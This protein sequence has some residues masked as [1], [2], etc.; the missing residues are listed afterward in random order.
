MGQN[1]PLLVQRARRALRR[2]DPSIESRTFLYGADFGTLPHEEDHPNLVKIF[3]DA[4]RDYLQ[5]RVYL[6]SALVT[7]PAGETVVVHSTD[8]PPTEESERNLLIN[9]VGGV[10]TAMRQVADGAQAPVHLYCY[11]RYDQRVLLEALKRHLDDVSALPGFFDLMTQTPALSQ[12]IISFLSSELQERYNLGSVCTPLHDAARML[13]F[14]WA[15]DQ[16]EYYR[17][18]RAR[19]FDN[20]RDVIRQPDGQLIP[21]GKDTPQDMPNRLTI[22]AA[23]RFNSQI[24]LE[25]AYAAWGCLP[26]D[27]EDDRTLLPFRQITLAHLQA[28]AG[29]RVRA[30]AHIE[31]SFKYKAR[32]IEKP[33]F[34][35]PNLAQ[36]APAET[37]LAK[38]LQEFLF[39]EHHAAVQAKLLTYSLPIER[40]VQT[41]LALLLRYQ[42]EQVAGDTYRFMID[43]ETVGLDLVLTLNALR[44]KEGDWVVINPAEASLRASKIKNGRLATIKAIGPDW[45]ELN[46][47]GMTF[48][49]STFRYPHNNKLVPESGQFYTLDEMA[50]DMNADKTLEALG[51][52]QENIL[53][54]WLLQRSNQRQVTAQTNSFVTQF[55]KLIDAIEKPRQLTRPQHEVIVDRLAEPLFLVQGPP[56][57]G[58][59]H[60]LAWAVL[61]R[62]AAHAAQ[63]Q[64]CHV[65]VSCKTHNAVNIVLEALAAKWQRL[66]NAV[67]ASVK[68]LQ[69][70]QIYKLVNDETDD[71]PD[72]VQP[73]QAFCNSPQTLDKLM[74]QGLIVIGGT[75][76][77][78]Y[79]LAKY[80]G[81]GGKKIDWSL[82]SFDLVVVDEASQMSLPEGILAC[83]FLKLTGSAIVVG[84]HRQMPPIIAHNWESEEKRSIT[85]TLPYL[86]LFDAL[87]ERDFPRVA[88]DESFRLHQTVAE[89]LQ[90]N[91]YI[92]D[93][94][95]FFSRRKELLPAV[96]KTDPFIDL[97]LDSRYP[98][99]VIE[100]S[101]RQSQQYNELEIALVEPLIDACTTH[102]WLDGHHGV[103]VVVPHRAQKARLREHFPH[104]AAAEAIDTVERFQGGERDVII[105]SATVSDPDYVLAEADFL[106][107]LNRLNVA[108]S[109]P[110]KK[111]I[112]VASRSVIE[113]LTSDLEV[114]ENAMIW[115]RLY[116]Q[117]A[118][119]LLWQGEQCG[120][121]ISVRGRQ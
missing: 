96:P 71:V 99:V 65:A 45:I 42:G 55:T 10:I 94:I 95:H 60:T 56:G 117:Y 27:S 116:Y 59:S 37:T 111:L 79:N 16:Y 120:V 24:P 58:K 1:L 81:A 15:D 11:N 74:T 114:F 110:R 9:W 28:F 70:L 76:G 35:L 115:K 19:L 119:D 83:A 102:L 21:A 62:L 12:S 40:R 8:E 38:S 52:T 61:A 78:L 107:N 30:L 20:R 4:Q 63:G 6:I 46:L 3:F 75:P 44:L 69:N 98:V 97:A 34:N 100:H 36:A 49:Q 29:H 88:L 43:C 26:K 93:G 106:L 50:D 47:L 85:T 53:Y 105:V 104:L 86:S 91:I 87:R 17:L 51:Y 112:V 72:G 39:M 67:T 18:F 5:D 48:W 77:G 82:K 113:L 13:G 25:Y 33:P 54:Q 109:R 2:F 41:G 101:E 89:F 84:D 103:G 108:L 66:M 14:N 73:L 64:P 57:T 31:G 121:P 90:D 80:R 92:H 32:W 7:G 118:S 22:E 68:P 23:S